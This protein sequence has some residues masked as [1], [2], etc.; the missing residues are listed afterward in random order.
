[1]ATALPIGWIVGWAIA[2]VVVFIAVSLLLM[3]IGLGRRIVGQ[4]EY[5]REALDGSREHTAPL[6]EV[7][8]T[9][10]SLD[11]ITRGLRAVRREE[12]TP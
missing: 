12:R 6:F 7:R 1:M 8:R 10:L 2:G 9:N 11:R 3:I 4:A 5:V